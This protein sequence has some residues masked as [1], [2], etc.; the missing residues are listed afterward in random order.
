MQRLNRVHTCIHQGDT[1]TTFRPLSH[2]PSKSL[3]KERQKMSDCKRSTMGGRLDGKAGEEK[4]LCSFTLK[5]HN[6]TPFKKQTC[7]LVCTQQEGIRINIY[8]YRYYYYIYVRSQCN[9]IP[10]EKINKN[11]RCVILKALIA[12]SHWQFHTHLDFKYSL[13]VKKGSNYKTKLIQQNKNPL[14]TQVIAEVP[15]TYS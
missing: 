13:P 5:T 15:V 11:T 14:E 7:L 1:I 9:H 12:S 4:M 3:L 6:C 10:N 8:T 2:S